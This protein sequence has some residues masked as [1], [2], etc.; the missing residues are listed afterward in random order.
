[1]ADFKAELDQ[2]DGVWEEMNLAEKLVNR[3]CRH[4]GASDRCPLTFLLVSTARRDDR[5]RQTA[6]KGLR[7][8]VRSARQ[9]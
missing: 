8:K 1:M 6:K 5:L 9:A 3:K 7:A 2:A 4:D